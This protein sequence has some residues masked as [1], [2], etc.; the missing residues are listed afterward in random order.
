MGCKRF[1]FIK[2]ARTGCEG[3]CSSRQNLTV[4]RMINWVVKKFFSV[5]DIKFRFID[6]RES[7]LQGS[8]TGT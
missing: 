8:E 2:E 3:D 4:E 1:G 7:R 5:V 6:Y